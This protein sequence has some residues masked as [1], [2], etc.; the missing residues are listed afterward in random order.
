MNKILLILV[1]LSVNQLSAQA[2]Y[3]FTASGEH[4]NKA[5]EYLKIKDYWNAFKS[6]DNIN[7]SDTLYDLAQFNKL[8]TEYNGKY[9]QESVTTASK[10]ID[11]ESIY[12]PEA[13]FYTIKS[14]IDLRLYADALAS[15]ASGSQKYP[16]QSFRFEYLKA[17][18]FDTQGKYDEA[19][20]ILHSIL[21]QHP[22]HS[23]SHLL[24]AQIMGEEGGLVQSILAFQ[25]AIIS[26]RTSS[27]LRPAFN[28]MTDIMQGNF[29]IKREKEGPKYYKL[30]NSLISSGLALKEDYKSALPLK[31]I[32]NTVTDLIINQ[33]SY[34][35]NSQNF[36]MDYYVKFLDEVRLEG[37]QKGYVLYILSVINHSTVKKALS[38]YKSDVD[39][40]EDFSVKYW[41]KEVNKNK[42]EVNGAIDE[43]DYMMNKQGALSA[44]GQRNKEGLKIGEWTFF[45]PSGKIAAQ[46]EY[47]E[48]GRLTG[49]NVWY[50]EEGYIKESGLYED[51]KING[52]AY[53]TREN[54][55]SSYDGE[56]LDGELSGN[57]RIYNNQGILYMSKTFKNN[58]ISGMV[59][60]FYNNGELMSSVNVVKGLNEG[61]LYVFSPNGDT[62]KIRSFS[63][64]KPIGTHL[65]YHANG[66]IKRTGQYKLGRRHG[67]WKDYYYDGSLSFKYNYKKGYLH[68][69]YLNFTSDGDTLVYK[70]YS[71]GL[72][73]GID[74]D[75]IGNNKVLWEHVFKNGKLKKYYNYD[76]N[77]LL[78]SKGKKEY[79]LHDRFGFKYIEATKKGRHFNGQYNV[80]WKNGKV[81]EKRIYVKG[82]LSGECKSYFSWG[83]VDEVKYYY[84]D[85]LHGNYKSYYDNG[86]LYASGQYVHGHQ[87]GL[88]LYYHPNGNLYKEI[89]FINGKSE[90]HTTFYSVTGEK[91][92]NYFY[93]EGVLNKSE[94]FDQEGNI[95][96]KIKT[97]QGNGSYSFKSIAGHLYLKSQL[98]GGEYHGRKTFYY[99]NGQIAE[100]IQKNYGESHGLFR[101][102]HPDGSLKEEG[103][104]TYGKKSGEWKVYFHNGKLSLKA[105]YEN[106]IVKD[107]LIK[108]Y[109][110]GEVKEIIFYDQN[111]NDIGV[112]YFHPSG[113]VNS[114]APKDKGFTH[115][116]FNNYDAFGELA[117]HREYNGGECVSYSYLKDGKLIDPIFI[118]GNGRVK[119]FYNNGNV[120]S[121]YTE[122]KGLYEGHYKRAFSNGKPW[123]ETN[124]LHDNIDGSYRSFFS[125]GTLRYEAEYDFGRLDGVQKKYN[126][127]GKLLSEITFNQGIKEG[128][129]KFYNDNGNLMYILLYKDDVVVEIDKLFREE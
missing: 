99:P 11:N 31:Y 35:S 1:F 61:G 108:Y 96:C 68:G 117:I 29:E 91:K 85:N 120:A 79:L 44:F 52:H 75:Y 25:M 115:G 87:T 113:L 122:K 24:L 55:C 129:S 86:K 88:W 18:I 67:E 72:L 77:G 59:K 73:N 107:S 32:T 9:Y 50:S 39:R 90:G 16:L 98:K 76:P 57:V 5:Y 64:G 22:S 66:N 69:D 2:D 21:K 116:K 8:I 121:E 74:K 60:E 100:E 47:N 54:G 124:Y 101:S 49:E 19:K 106:D 95:I 30:I 17:K 42:F 109:I 114:F 4:F 62:V 56:F 51:G 27:S 3:T 46:T 12:S 53:F 111:G 123:V 112:K 92:A 45:Y 63:K 78:I 126:H 70:I 36:T 81:K 103:N 83:G 110:T 20:N 28:G 6:F 93:K 41:N 43:R 15:I 84:Q 14:Q 71:N 118:N 94:V 13:Y 104:Y 97:P 82:V 23:A 125:D 58:Q 127:Y 119:T 34:Q 65:E 33:L 48:K 105:S 37:L 89:Y 128:K 38:T 102:Y 26:N 7:K 10:L 40:F 80:F